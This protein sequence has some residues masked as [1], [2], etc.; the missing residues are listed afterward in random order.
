MKIFANKT[1]EAWICDRVRNEFYSSFPDNA[2]ENLRTADIFW[3][4]APWLL[5][6]FSLL[7]GR[8]TL[9]SIYHIVPEKFNKKRLLHMDQHTT[10]FHVICDKTKE[11]ISEYVTKPIYVA[12]FWI[13]QSIFFPLDVTESRTELGVPLDKFI[14][15]SFQRDTEGHDLK[16]PKLE[17]GPDRFCDIVE[18]ISKEKDVHVLLGGWRRQ[19]IIKRLN[20]SKI[21]FTYIERPPLKII[22]KM[23][24]C[25]DLYVVAAR[26]EG[27]PQS[28]P[29]SCA[30]KTPIISTNVGCAPMYLDSSRI[31]PFPHYAPALN[32]DSKLSFHYNKA[33]EKFIPQGVD[34]FFDIFNKVYHSQNN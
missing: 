33:K 34:L 26:H 13:N 17:K 10:A 23:Y 21:P 11:F 3:A 22:N 29:E 19:Y 15:G 8:K 20:A 18:E 4:V 1:P 6:D 31:Y 16:T 2:T 7:R 28:I 24:N 25:L 27:G 5:R 30:T 12:P 32:S 14:I 9:T